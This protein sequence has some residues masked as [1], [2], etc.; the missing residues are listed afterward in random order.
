MTETAEEAVV[1]KTARVKEELVIH[2][3]ATEHIE[4]VRDTLRREEAE[5]TQ[6]PGNES[7][8]RTTDLSAPPRTGSTPSKS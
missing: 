5:V 6:E 1:A 8:P 3:D 4:T 2:K 7:S